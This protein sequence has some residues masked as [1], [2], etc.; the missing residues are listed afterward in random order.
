M[1][2]IKEDRWKTAPSLNLPRSNHSS[3]YI[4]EAIFT[5]GGGAEALLSSIEKLQKPKDSQ[6]CW[7]LLAV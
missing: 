4:G 7:E 3:C 2:I 5:F 1:Y 6:S